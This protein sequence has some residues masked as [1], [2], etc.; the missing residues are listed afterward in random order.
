MTSILQQQTDDINGLPYLVKR[1]DEKRVYTFDAS[2]FPEIISGLQISSLVGSI[3]VTARGNVTASTPPTLGTPAV[4]LTVIQVSIDAG[5]N[6]ESYYMKAQAQL[7]DA[8]SSVIDLEGM[9]YIRD[10]KV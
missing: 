9:L 4:G 5:D 10:P 6:E 2:L 8:D 3:T 7:N 1:S